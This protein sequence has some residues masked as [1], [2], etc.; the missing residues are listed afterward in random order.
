MIS[1]TEVHYLLAI[2]MDAVSAASDLVRSHVPHAFTF[3]GDRDVTS[4]VDLTVEQ[5]VRDT[6]RKKSPGVGFL[7]EE[8]GVSRPVGCDEP[9]WVLDPIDGT[10]NFIHGVP[11]CAVSLSL[12]SSDQTLIAVIDLP[13]LA[14]QYSAL[15][16]GGAYVND[17]RLCVSSTER[18]NAAL[19][20][21]DQFTFDEDAQHK[22]PMRRN[23]IKHLAPRVQ[24]IRMLGASAI[25]L[26]WTAHGRLDACVILG[27]KR[28]D[29]SAGVLIAREAGARVLDLD[30]SD[31]SA[32]S[33]AT[34]AFTPGLEDELMAALR[35]SFTE[36]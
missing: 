29:T 16:G 27:N 33:S 11:L 4:D 23:L 30:G 13:F 9:H 5:H 8:E 10:V 22:N 15:R 12:V 2:A 18:L 21:I 24:R 36:A 35:A 28:W 3:K 17:Q 6:L 19:I 25:D 34:I 1:D 32:N 26:A 14:T 20:S 7:G 31:H